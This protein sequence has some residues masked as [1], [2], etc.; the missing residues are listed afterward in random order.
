MKSIFKRWKKN[1]KRILIIFTGMTLGILAISIGLSFFEDALSFSKEMSNGNNKISNT[2]IYTPST[3]N[4]LESLNTLDEIVKELNTDYKVTLGSVTYPMDR[5]VSLSDAPSIIPVA[6]N[7][8]IN[9]KPNII[10]GRY[11]TREETL[12]D[13]KFAVIGYDIYKKLFQNENFN[14]EMKIMIY[15]HN[16]NIIG[17]VGRTKRYSPQNSQ[18]EIPYRNYFDFYT[19]EPDINKIPIFIQ[20]NKEFDLVNNNYKELTLVDKPK[21][22][23]DIRIPVKLVLIVGGLILLTTTINESNLFS[24]WIL[25]RRKEIAIKKA[26]GATDT[27]IVIENL[28]ETL[29][30]S[31]ISA[32]ISLGIQY[33]IQIKLNTILYNYELEV[34]IVNFIIAITI[35]VLIAICTSLIPTKIILSIHASDELKR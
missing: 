26:L 16:Y 6:Y 21:Y 27:I 15:G 19:E 7:K 28:S 13:K 23:N 25:S 35:S 12:S 9:W 30:L 4:S 10:Y 8:S 20:G 29:L 17:V 22:E 11:L 33:I 18:I 3:N 5:A 32:I 2:L 1:H 24:L 34:T 31:F 14:A